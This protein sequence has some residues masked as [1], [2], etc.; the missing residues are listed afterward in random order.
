MDATGHTVT[1]F[2]DT[3]ADPGGVAQSYCV[4]SVDTHMGESPCSNGVTG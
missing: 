3:A 2:T 4:T 1:S